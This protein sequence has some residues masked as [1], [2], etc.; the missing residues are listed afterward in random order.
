MPLLLFQFSYGM[1][2]SRIRNKE[3]G[4]GITTSLRPSFDAEKLVK[5]PRAKNDLDHLAFPLALCFND[6]TVLNSSG[7]R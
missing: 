5:I 4:V 1:P 6:G 2:P 7:R 3:L